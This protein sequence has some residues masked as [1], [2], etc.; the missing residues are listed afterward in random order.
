[1]TGFEYTITLN[2]VVGVEGYFVIAGEYAV[3]V[4]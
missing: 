1:M 2:K 3:D 4:L